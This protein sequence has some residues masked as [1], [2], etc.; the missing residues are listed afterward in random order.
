[1]EID[2]ENDFE[3][4][5]EE[6]LG[7]GAYAEEAFKSRFE[8]RPN[9]SSGSSTAKSGQCE[10]CDDLIGMRQ[11]QVL[12]DLETQRQL[13][14]YEEEC[15]RRDVLKVLPPHLLSSLFSSIDFAR[16]TSANI[17]SFAAIIHFHS[18]TSAD[19]N[20]IF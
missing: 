10:L 15:S 7:K 19:F 5:P 18:S 14:A 17:L 3:A 4:C 13:L 20:L 8:R 2:H 12:L 11:R 9:H 6:E 1:M 16:H